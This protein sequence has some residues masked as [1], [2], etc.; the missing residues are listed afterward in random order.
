MSDGGTGPRTDAGTI[1]RAHRDPG[2]CRFHTDHVVVLEWSAGTGWAE[3]SLEPYGAFTMD[4]AAS[5][6]HY[7][8]S[9]FEGLK[10]FRQPDGSAALFR[11]GDHARRMARSAWRLAMA[12]M[13]TELFQRAC[14]E[15]AVADDAWIPGGP[16]QSLYIR[17]LMVANESELGLRDSARYRCMFLAYPVEPCFGR[18]FAPISVT[19]PGDLVRAVR[20]GTGEAKCAGNYAAS[21]RARKEAVARGFHEVLWLDGLERRWVEELSGMNV[22]FVWRDASGVRLTTPE[23]RGTIVRGITRDC[24]LTLARDAGIPVSQEPTSIDALVDG[25]TSGR[26]VE[27]FACGTAAVVVPVGRVATDGHDVTVGD[28]REG[29]VTARLRDALT[30]IQHGVRPDRH[31]WLRN[32]RNDLASVRTG[33]HR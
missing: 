26:L 16:G 1:A 11:V 19:T 25:A 22:F 9:I 4:P 13:P 18:D 15:L 3:P 27:M 8:Q 17:P 5:V 33:T 21:L 7:G 2:F 14:A 32:V 24:L 20:G 28:G 29:P 12:E 31:G 23:C 10:V 6:L 30:G